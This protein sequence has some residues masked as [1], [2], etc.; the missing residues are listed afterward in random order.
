[1]LSSQTNGRLL[2][3]CITGDVYVSYLG[4]LKEC[5]IVAAMRSRRSLWDSDSRVRKFRTPDSDSGTKKL[6]SDSDSRTYCVTLLIV[7]IRMT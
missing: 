3:N 2:Y 7:Y 6:D 4:C 5:L 1:M